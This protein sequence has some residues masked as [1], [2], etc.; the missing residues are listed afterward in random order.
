MGMF[1]ART[2]DGLRDLGL[3]VIRGFGERVKEKDVG[4]GGTNLVFLGVS[5]AFSVGMDAIA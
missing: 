5:D 4:R 3:T 2:S 1:N